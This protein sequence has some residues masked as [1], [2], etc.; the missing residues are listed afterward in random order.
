M[1]HVG[2]GISG[3]EG[4][5]AVN[6]S[7]FAIA[8]FRFLERLL[9]VH[10][11]WNFY[12]MSKLVLFSFYKNGVLAGLTTIFQKRCLYSGVIL[13]DQWISSSF[14]FVSF[15]PIMI[16]A[17]FDR[18]L[19][20]SYVISNPQVYASG[21]NNEFMSKRVTIRWFILVIMTILSIYYFTYPSLYQHGMMTSAS[22]GLMS[23]RSDPGDGEGD[24][25]TFGTQIYTVLI[26]T[27]GF[28]V[29]H[30]FCAFIDLDNKSDHNVLIVYV[31]QYLNLVLSY[32]VNFH[33]AHVV[34][35]VPHRMKEDSVIGW[36]GHGLV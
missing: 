21:P 31:R 6:S 9:L 22:S 14:N 17:F 27:L 2:V 24:F 18:D 25:K 7:D 19:E 12:R 10:G 33:L 29:S 23:G 16:I 11:R 13:F 4:Q 26:I 20:P 3:L 8:Q 30:I 34:G 28:K 5:Q 35:K 15:V 1:A 32:K 36:H